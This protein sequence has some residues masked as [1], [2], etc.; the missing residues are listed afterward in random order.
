MGDSGGDGPHFEWGAQTGAILVGCMTKSSLD[1]YCRKSGIS[2]NLRFGMDHARE[3]KKDIQNEKKV[4]FMDL[5]AIF[6]DILN[7]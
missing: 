5:T 2:I 1:D 6:D 7:A 3:N 4:N